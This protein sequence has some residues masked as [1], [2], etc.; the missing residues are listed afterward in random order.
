MCGILCVYKKNKFSSKDNEFINEILINAKTLKH[1]GESDHYNIINDKVLMYHNRLSINDLSSNGVQPMYNKGICIIVNGEIYNYKELYK[2]VQTELPDYEFLSKSDS[3]IIIPLYLLYGYDFIN[4]LKGM[5]SF[6]LYDGL[7]DELIAGRDHIGII[8]MYYLITDE[9]IAFSSEMKA[10]VDLDINNKIHIFKPNTIFI[11]NAFHN[12][13]NYDWKDYD[14]IP[15][16][17]YDKEELNNKLTNTVLEHTLS[18]VP[19]GILLSGGLDSSLIASIMNKLKK[20]NKINNEIR[21]FTIGFENASD[22]IAAEKVAKYLGSN[23]TSYTFTKEE[24]L[25]AIKDIIFY[26]ETY[27]ITT[28]RA[29]IPMYLLTKKIKK[30]TNI[31]VLLSGEGS[32]ELFGGYLY[33]HKAPNKK[34]FQHE[35]I[36]K[37][38]NLH[39]YDCLRANKS[40]MANTIEI[41]VPFL[42]KDFIDYVMNIDTEHKMINEK[43]KN[44]EKYILRDAFDDDFL[45]DEILWRQ[46]DQFSDAVSSKEE[47]WIDSLKE[48]ADK[49]VSDE[50]F[51]N[52]SI[53]FPLHTPI[54]KEHYLYRKIFEEFYPFEHCVKT[55]DHNAKSISCSTER[56]FK[57][58]NL[59]EDSK[60]ND[61]SGKSMIDIY[62]N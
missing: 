49:L 2:L 36:D 58:M 56:A 38:L 48:Y 10:L 18:D 34:E 5:F 22:I 17:K 1:R 7:H 51:E 44:I 25:N 62:K 11:N 37:M 55:V 32:D 31:K 45:P 59:S 20:E 33:F 61:A 27:D 8:S 3:E 53:K 29:S 19:I 13:Y 12:S 9:L 21:T 24:G 57:W 4:Y 15:K 6:V 16:Q 40:C 28:I 60:L 47:N 42:D 43:N 35:L 26:L 50:E 14:Y 30:E 23:H 39:K 41:R 52:R 54:S 46:K